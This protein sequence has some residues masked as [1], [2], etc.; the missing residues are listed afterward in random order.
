MKN[1]LQTVI[2]G[3]S[4]VAM[5]SCA[6]HSSLTENLKSQNTQVT[7]SQNNFTMGERIEGDATATY[8]FGFGGLSKKSL[9]E[10]A[11]KSMYQNANLTGSSKALINETFSNKTSFYLIVWKHQVNV[12]ADVIEF[13]K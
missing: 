7:L 4:L 8:V 11:R 5:S 9:L 6:S 1:Y 12:S 13:T 3:I 2:L 10:T